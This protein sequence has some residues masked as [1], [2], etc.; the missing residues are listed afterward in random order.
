MKRTFHAGLIA[1]ICAAALT[2]A[3]ARLFAQVHAAG[4]QSV[5]ALMGGQEPGRPIKNPPPPPPQLPLKSADGLSLLST[6]GR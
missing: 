4:A 1:L 6:N 3:S 2:P 5:A